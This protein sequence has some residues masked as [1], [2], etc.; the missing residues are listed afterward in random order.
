MTLLRLE[1]YNFLKIGNSLLTI[2]ILILLYVMFTNPFVSADSGYYLSIM[3]EMHNGS[4]YFKDIASP[5]NPLAISLL[6][7][8]YYFTENTHF[9]YHLLINCMVIL[10]SGYLLLLIISKLNKNKDLCIFLSLFFIIISLI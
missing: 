2:L 4:I 8:P 9:N 6:S 7:F 10:T 5:Y 3:R 1:N